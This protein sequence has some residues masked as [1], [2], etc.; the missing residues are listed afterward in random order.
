VDAAVLSED[1]TASSFSVSLTTKATRPPR[2]DKKQPSHS[3]LGGGDGGDGEEKVVYVS[4]SVQL[5]WKLCKDL[6]VQVSFASIVGL[7][8]LYSR[9]LLPL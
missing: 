5:L 7:F 6:L 9:S 1:W 4:G 8:C 2:R 3:P